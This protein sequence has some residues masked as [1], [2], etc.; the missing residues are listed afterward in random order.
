LAT[1]GLRIGIAKAGYLH[2]Y[3]PNPLFLLTVHSREGMLMKMKKPNFFLFPEFQSRPG[4]SKE[5]IT[6]FFG[7]PSRNPVAAMA[8]L[9][10]FLLHWQFSRFKEYFDQPNGK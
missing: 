8:P 1:A 3:K 6:T 4:V 5:L 10:N 9:G 2:S 7:I